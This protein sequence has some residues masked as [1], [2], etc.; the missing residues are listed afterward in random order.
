[1]GEGDTEHYPAITSDDLVKLYSSVLLNQNT[2]LGLANKVQFNIHLFF[3]RGGAENMH[4][5]SK[6]TFK[7]T[8]INSRD[9]VVSWISEASKNHRDDKDA[10]YGGVI[11]SFS[12]SDLC[13][14]KSF[15]KYLNCLHPG[16]VSLWQRPKDSLADND[17]TWYHKS[18]IGFN[19]LSSFIPDLSKKL[20]LSKVCTNHLI[21]SAS[22][23]I[24]S[25]ANFNPYL[26]MSVSGHQ[27]ATSVQSYATRVDDSEKLLIAEKLNNTWVSNN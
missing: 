17:Q 12:S 7:V 11:P 24:P 13:P 3:C 19:K 25:N 5:M 26:I 4:G 27:S 15:T 2:P 8:Q 9:A 16:C 21:R 6:S 14:V 1:M 10:A 18:P 22:I 20:K 23:D